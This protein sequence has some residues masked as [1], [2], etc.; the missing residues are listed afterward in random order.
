L[1]DGEDDT[2]WN[3]DQGSPQY[4]LVKFEKIVRINSI[5]I[6]FQGGFAGKV[7]EFQIQP[8]TETKQFQLH[9]AFFPE[10]TNF[11]QEF[12]L[13]GAKAKSIKIIFK[14]STDFYGRITIY[15]LS[16]NIIEDDEIA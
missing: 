11:H 16:M 5:T 10:D 13:G 7:C 12:Q 9:S 1:F 6:M 14:E 4:I 2:C 15:H 3:S 8:N